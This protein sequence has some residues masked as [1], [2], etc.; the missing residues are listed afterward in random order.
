[1]AGHPNPSSAGFSFLPA[2]PVELAAGV[3]KIPDVTGR[4][5][6][7]SAARYWLARSLCSGIGAFLAVRFLLRYLQTR[8]MTPFAG[9]TGQSRD[10]PASPTPRS[11]DHRNRC[12]I[13]E[14]DQI[15]V[16]GDRLD[17]PA[18]GTGGIGVHRVRA[19]G[20]VAVILG[21]VAARRGTVPLWAV[22]TAAVAVAVDSAGYLIGRRWGEQ[23]GPPAGSRSSAVTWTG[24]SNPRGHI[25]AR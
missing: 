24:T 2:T 14:E 10:S 9:T 8:V 25:V 11:D 13:I 5:A 19:H 18:A 4:L 21:G 6:R 23:R 15:P 16:A 17:V 7:A 12:V 1:V 22:I 3:L 20:E